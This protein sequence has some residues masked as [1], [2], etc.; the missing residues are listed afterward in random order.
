[1]V[2][3]SPDGEVMLWAEMASELMH[4]SSSFPDSQQAQLQ[5]RAIHRADGSATLPWLWYFQHLCPGRLQTPL[6]C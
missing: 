3:C 5:P 4:G 1:M 2:G 6:L